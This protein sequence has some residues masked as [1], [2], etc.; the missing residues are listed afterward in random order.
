VPLEGTNRG[1][2]YPQNPFCSSS[3]ECPCAVLRTVPQTSVLWE[4]YE[5]LSDPYVCPV[6]TEACYTNRRHTVFRLVALSPG[7]PEREH[8]G[9]ISIP[10]RQ[11]PWVTPV[12]SAQMGIQNPRCG[13]NSLSLAGSGG[14][15]KAP[16]WHESEQWATC[17]A[18][19]CPCHRESQQVI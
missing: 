2:V 19:P 13:P 15:W 5:L 16:A 7:K 12:H 4:T 18:R 14:F 1:A 9:G 8:H 17:S 6:P 11:F 3:K 10:G